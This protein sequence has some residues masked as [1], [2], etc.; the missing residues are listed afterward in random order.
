MIAILHALLHITSGYGNSLREYSAFRVAVLWRKI[1]EVY[2]RLTSSQRLAWRTSSLLAV[3]CDDLFIISSFGN[4]INLSLIVI[5][6]T[7]S[8]Y[9]WTGNKDTRRTITI[10]TCLC[11]TSTR[12]S[13]FEPKGTLNLGSTALVPR[14]LGVPQREPPQ[15]YPPRL[16]LLR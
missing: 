12:R 14:Q 13:P 3:S 8:E 15:R 16:L 11:P 4:F 1:F 9:N 6:N 2:G 10:E 5:F 7:I